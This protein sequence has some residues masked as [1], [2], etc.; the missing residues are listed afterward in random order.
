MKTIIKQSVSR[1][2]CAV[3]F[4]FSMFA[5]VQS[6]ACTASFIATPDTAG[7]GVTFTSTSTGT[8][9]TTN[10]FW[11]FGDGTGSNNINDHHQYAVSGW[12][13]VCLTIS[14]SLNGCYSIS[15]DSVL[16]GTN[17]VNCLAAF[18]FQANGL[19]A[20]FIDQSVGVN[21]TYSWDF[22][23]G[24]T[25]SGQNA[26]HTYALAGQ[27]LVCL[28]ISNGTCSDTVCSYVVVTS[29][30]GNCQASFIAFD[31]AGTYFFVNTS[32][33][34]NFF[35]SYFWDFGDGSYGY[36]SDPMHVYNTAG[37]FYVCLT[38]TDS[39]AGCY[40]TFC[41]SVAGG[42][43]ANCQ[44]A[45]NAMPDSAG[46][47]YTF[48]DASTG[49]NLL[50]TYVWTVSDGTTATGITFYHNF[51]TQG[52]YQ[53]CLTIT[54]YD[55]L[56]NITCSSNTCDS[57]Y[58]G[59]GGG[60]TCNA[61]WGSQS[62]LFTT[63]FA[64]LSSGTDT[65][66]SWAWDFGDGSTSSQQNPIH[67][68]SQSGYY[69]VCLTIQTGANGAVTCSDTYCMNIYAG[70]NNT[71]CQANFS[72]YPD[73]SGMGFQFQNI[74]TGTTGSTNYYWTFGD[75]QSSTQ[76]NPFHTYAITG[77][78]IVCLTISDSAA[79]CTSTYCD[80]LSVGQSF[81]CNPYFVWNGDSTNGVQFYEFNNNLPGIVYEWNFG[82]GDSSTLADPYHQYAA[83]GTYY[84]CLTVFQLDSNGFVLCT[85]NYCDSIYVG[86]NAAC[87]PQITAVPDSNG[88]GNGN[89]NFIVT[90]PCGNITNVTWNY[91]DGT[92]GTGNYSSHQYAGTGWYWVCVDVE[93]NGIIYTQC[94]SIFALR[95]LGVQEA[96]NNISGINAYPNPASSSMNIIYSIN[97]AHN[98]SIRLYDV[99]GREVK[100]LM[101]E[102]QISGLHNIAIDVKDITEGIYLLKITA[103]ESSA[104]ARIVVNR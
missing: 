85:G 33:G 48:Y 41:D 104:T 94:D 68:Y 40:S 71:G 77:N 69:Y 66:V 79:N 30:G 51:A 88:W 15:C 27:Y 87:A 10:Y 92:F 76:E 23:D 14:D 24:S 81:F 60:A 100:Q 8:S 16:A 50:T 39:A 7:S 21:L 101:E 36:T 46:N 73:S 98:V 86:A 56:Q 54:V 83:A 9:F 74:S 95:M 49:T 25:G 17:G 80:S 84:A 59:N 6:H 45:F 26:T 102:K 34:T 29:G 2:M 53:V 5:A 18:S 13:Q 82:D 72:M 43:G 35:T 20:T 55:S 62:N 4:F 64:D 99:T 44:A 78:Y 11:D 37:P 19:T 3:L 70:N 31:S 57:V 89:V 28:A 47:G 58:A 42:N 61:Y 1:T 96:A 22:G 90:S 97:D 32:T 52:W 67:T 38:I 75:N 65:V 63:Y 12:Y 103:D 93:V 91:G